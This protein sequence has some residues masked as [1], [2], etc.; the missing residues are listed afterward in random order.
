MSY[1][2]QLSDPNEFRRCIRDLVALATLPAMW[3]KYDPRQIADSAAA[4]LL[5]ML[6]ADLVFVALPGRRDALPIEIVRT[7][8]TITP[9][10][11]AVICAAMHELS[12][13]AVQQSLTITN[14]LG[15]GMP[16]LPSASAE[17]RSWWSARAIWNSRPTC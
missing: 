14:P 6:H 8:K 11:S 7:G 5:S 16:A 4:A 13:P 1:V 3:Q 9:R 17:T 15:E 2:E 10:L 12:A